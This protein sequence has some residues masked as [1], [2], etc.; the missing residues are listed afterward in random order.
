MQTNNTVRAGSKQSIAR[1]NARRRGAR[2]VPDAS[3][4]SIVP[5]ATIGER[6]SPASDREASFVG[7]RGVTSSFSGSEVPR[8]GKILAFATMAVTS[9][10]LPR[11]PRCPRSVAREF[12]LGATASLGSSSMRRPCAG[13]F[14]L[15]RSSGSG[16]AECR[17][18]TVLSRGRVLMVAVIVALVSLPMSAHAESTSDQIAK[19]SAV[20]R[21]DRR[22]VV[23]EPARRQRPRQ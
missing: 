17:K 1:S 7:A 23:P 3:I 4:S 21:Q 16:V 6:T 15:G 22:S 2:T 18:D 8:I 14:G 12:H 20:D 11:A 10:F 9:T 19:T 5:S 13:R